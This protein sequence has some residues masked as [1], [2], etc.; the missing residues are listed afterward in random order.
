VAIHIGQGKVDRRALPDPE[1]HIYAQGPVSEAPRTEIEIELCAIWAQM[2]NLPAVG[3]D[4]DFFVLGGHSLLA[5]KMFAA[6]DE[7]FGRTYPLSLLLSSPTIR[8][9]AEHFDRPQE[10][11]RKLTSLIPLR[12]R[13]N[14]P[15]IFAVPGVFGNILG[16]VDL[17]RELGDDQ[18]FYALQSVGLDGLQPP[19]DSIEAIAALYINEIQSVQGYGP[20]AIIGACFGATVAYEITRQLLAAGNEVAYLGL[21]DPSNREYRGVNAMRSRHFGFWKKTCAVVDLISSRIKLY[22]N[23]LRNR[24]G[25]ERIDYAMRKMISIGVTLTDG[26]KSKRLARELHQLEVARANRRA[27]RRY[28]PQSLSGALTTFEV[29]ESNHPRNRRSDK[30]PWQSL[31]SGEVNTHHFL[32]KDSGDLV[33]TNV[34]EL[35]RI[36]TERLNAVRPLG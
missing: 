13:G 3:I 10:T 27:F 9:L 11:R 5:A 18:P 2:L 21:I 30:V 23:E 25:R 35:S 14:R 36:I 31:W 22:S 33:R 34:V 24:A 26:N 6:L 28:R 19:L 12:S 29:F 7:K 1:T 15:S 16:Y 17:A 4:D 32:A 20:Y 8:Q